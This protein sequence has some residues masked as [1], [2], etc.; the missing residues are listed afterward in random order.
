MTGL[1]ET[2]RDMASAAFAQDPYPLYARLRRER[3]VYQG[4]EGGWYLTRYADADAALRDPRLSK[5][6][7]RMRRWYAARASGQDVGLLRDRFA[8]SMLHADPPAHTRLRKL[9]GKALSA[10]RVKALRPQVE[11]ITNEL[12]DAAVAAGPSMDVIAALAYP[13]PLAVI[14]QLLGVPPH[15]HHRL[16]VWSRQLANQ[17][18]VVLAA[19]DVRRLEQAADELEDYLWDLIRKRRA[20]PSDDVVSALATAGTRDGQLT[21][22]ELVS[23]CYLLLVA[24]HQ[25]T[26]NLI[27]NGVLALLENPDQLRRVQQHPT[28]FRPAV[29]ELLR[30][31]SSVQAVTRIVVGQVQIGGQT[32]NDG[33]LV[34]VMLGAAN[35]DPEWFTNPDRLDIGRPTN[36]HVSFG[37][38]PHFCLGAPLARLE[39]EVAIGQLVRRLPRLRLGTD[40]LQWRSKPALRGIQALPVTY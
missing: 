13:L 21:D 20:E 10:R 18:K 11:A 9:A 15:D 38:G 14:C 19:E 26:V 2:A 24:G 31:D 37:N 6:Q 22:E 25:T 17:T 7:E 36:R 3:P 27:G 23:T 1:D 16:G 35:R 4:A 5:D 32:L 30:Y 39:I 29:E 33:E 40:T 34:S 28:L 12:L 8:R